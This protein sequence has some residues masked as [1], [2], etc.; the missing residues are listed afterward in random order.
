MKHACLFLTGFWFAG[1]FEP[2]GSICSADTDCAE[3]QRCITLET[4]SVCLNVTTADAGQQPNADAA[5]I[6]VDGGSTADAGQPNTDSGSTPLDGGQ[7]PDDDG[8]VTPE[9]A[10]LVATLGRDHS[11]A[12]DGDSL[13]CWG[14]NDSGQLGLREA[15]Q[16]D[17]FVPVLASGTGAAAPEHLAAG[18]AFTCASYQSQ[19]WC[20]GR[21]PFSGATP[22][23]ARPWSVSMPNAA[24]VQQLA[25][26]FSHYCV[27]LS[28]GRVACSGSNAFG[29]LGRPTDAPNDGSLQ[30]VEGVDNVAE[31][32]LGGDQS[33]ALLSSG[34]VTC[35][36]VRPDHN[37]AQ[38]EPPVE[39][40]ALE[41]LGTVISLSVG[42]QHLCAVNTSFEVHCLG[43]NTYRQIDLE[44]ITRRSIT[45][46][47][48]LGIGVEYRAVHA[49]RYGTCAVTSD[50][51]VWCWGM[52]NTDQFIAPTQVPSL[53]SVR[54]MIPGS[55][56]RHYCAQTE[57]HEMFCW[58]LDHVGQL[59][60][61]KYQAGEHLTAAE[62]VQLAPGGNGSNENPATSC[63]QLV[64]QYP[65]Y[66]PG[67]FILRPS[68]S[69]NPI[70]VYCDL[71][72]TL[73]V[74]VPGT[75]EQGSADYEGSLWGDDDQVI[76]L[77]DD[78]TAAAA[79]RSPAYS[80]LSYRFVRI[81]FAS[82][83]QEGHRTLSFEDAPRASMQAVIS[84]G[85]YVPFGAGATPDDRDVWCQLLD[86]N[87]TWGFTGDLS[88]GYNATYANSGV[89]VGLA[90]RQDQ[91][92]CS[93]PTFA[94]LGVGGSTPSI[95]SGIGRS[96]AAVRNSNC[97]GHNYNQA[98]ASR[99]WV[100]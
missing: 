65:E 62:Q 43:D 92:S 28:G 75:T 95:A 42:A 41:G 32:A 4:R 88:A 37:P 68:G 5:L 67:R 19:V 61:A 54:N 55:M 97:T 2:P 7:V 70:E 8:G 25:A 26:G 84:R 79:Y 86:G 91:P 50:Q 64:E 35:W 9:P 71:G 17:R 49:A 85:E 22:E 45:Q 36:G 44:P 93:G 100:R 40:R 21:N 66:N 15:E 82:Q 14:A 74:M 89:R 13:R 38:G 24:S 59:G 1:C 29:Q 90:A 87:C 53:D 76:P 83:E 18:D 98:Y 6:P 11:C 33:C 52:T 94:Y 56:A 23:P 78:I 46:L 34:Q 27:L 12:V 57:D 16:G 77:P 58:G 80:A 81:G 51:Q 96:Y 3:N 20:W 60:R 31:L 39:A 10:G 73:L 30:F 47:E 99:V 63:R 72:W 69:E 48:P